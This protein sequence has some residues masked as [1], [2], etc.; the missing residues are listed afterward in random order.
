MLKSIDNSL[1]LWQV[2]E[3]FGY[4]NWDL[5]KSIDY[6]MLCINTFK[7][8]SSY[9]VT[10][11]NLLWWRPSK[12]H[13]DTSYQLRRSRL[14]DWSLWDDWG[15]KCNHSRT[16]TTAIIWPK[17]RLDHICRKKRPS[18]PLKVIHVKER[19]PVSSSYWGLLGSHTLYCTLSVLENTSLHCFWQVWDD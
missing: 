15:L 19:P 17:G 10:W 14:S 5:W 16:Q 13:F 2:S 7:R 9:G 8:P 18:W 6:F 4:S 11:R 1:R 12:V 3:L